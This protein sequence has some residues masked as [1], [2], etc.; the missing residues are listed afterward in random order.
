M[1]G[2]IVVAIVL[3][4]VGCGK[5]DPDPIG[6]WTP[7]STI[8]LAGIAGDGSYWKNGV[9]STL[10]ENGLWVQSMAVDGS[11]V[12]I[13]GLA[14]G[15]D[16]GNVLWYDGQE[17]KLTT[18]RGGVVLVAARDK[19]LFGVWSGTDQLPGWELYMNGTTIPID[20]TGWPTGL[21]LLGDDVY[22]SG[23]RHGNEY[24]WMVSPF[25][26][27]DTYA[28]CWKNGKEV[29]R[30]TDRS[31]A[32]TIFTHGDDVY[33]GGHSN[34]IPS[35]NKTACY[36]K[37]G[38]RVDLSPED[39][40]AEVKALFITESHVY[41]AGVI[42]GEAVYWKDGLEIIVSSEPSI[43]NSISVLGD[44]VYVAGRED[45]YPAVWK[46]ARRQDIPNQERQGEIKVVVAVKNWRRSYQ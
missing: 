19:K 43:A 8:H 2:C 31:Y 16:G 29:F 12:V 7:D 24:E 23:T 1:K 44:D 28:M 45:K 10:R 21:A 32:N 15:A 41:A 11:S 14:F 18:I 46:N 27:L 35:L 38:Q 37:N 25:Y 20:Y 30:E 22:I 6:A 42:D 9:H 36:W 17:I 33:M 34:H 39:K 13:G 4:L 26:S 3:C 40:D 5:D